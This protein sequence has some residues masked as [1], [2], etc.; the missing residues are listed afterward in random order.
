MNYTR[1][2]EG[3]DW[4]NYTLQLAQLRH[5]STNVQ[6]IPDK[7][8]GDAGVEF[9]SLDGCLY[10]SY[11]PEEVANIA[12]SSSAMKAKA[13]R[14][15]AK[16]T[17]NSAKIASLLQTVKVQRWILLCPFLDD[18]KVVAHVREQGAKVGKLS[19]LADNFEALVQSQEDFTIELA[20]LRNQSSGPH[21]K[22]TIAT[23][24]D[25]ERFGTGD[26]SQRLSEKLARAYPSAA[27]TALS[28]KKNAF[29]KNYA[30]RENAIDEYRQ[31][32]P[33]LWEKISRC[34]SAEESRLVSLG[35]Q[36]SSPIENLHNAQNNLATSLKQDVASVDSAVIQQ[37][38]L[39]TLTD[40]LMRCP[41]DF[42]AEESQ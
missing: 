6:R 31:E 12:K 37:I 18:K 24:V 3:K 10:Q 30:T 41:L 26:L 42:P 8:Q 7:V 25:A 13:T 28:E 1:A 15:L 35:A 29:I 16:L 22:F 32:H 4:Q 9:F 14:D 36:G 27:E 21:P 38:A 17:K 34:L 39:G 23:D 11:A 5:G 40:W 2:W 19:F 33:I 20:T